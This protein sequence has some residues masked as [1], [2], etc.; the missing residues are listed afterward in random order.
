MEE[1]NKEFEVH[2]G[3]FINKFKSELDIEINDLYQSYSYP[4]N[5][6]MTVKEEKVE[7]D[8]D[9]IEIAPSNVL[10]EMVQVADVKNE[11]IMFIDECD[12][13]DITNENDN[14]VR[15]QNDKKSFKCTLCEYSFGCEPYLESHLKIH[16]G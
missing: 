12:A 5:K 10:F 15:V 9:N 13:N 4:E 2:P 7:A 16:D 6:H 11:Q 8:A 1:E 3:V 14:Q